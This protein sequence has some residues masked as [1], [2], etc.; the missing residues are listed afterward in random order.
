M[1]RWFLTA[2][3]CTLLAPAAFAAEGGWYVGV[4]GGGSVVNISANE[5]TEGTFN[6]E[7][8]P[9]YFVGGTVGFDFGETYPAIGT[10]RVELEVGYRGNDIDKFEFRIDETTTGTFAAD[11]DVTVFSAMVNTFGEMRELAPFYPYLGGGIGV[12]Q[13]S[14]NDVTVSGQPFADESATVFAWQL[15]GGVG[16]RLNPHLVLDLG[17]R[18]FSAQDPSFTDAAGVKFDAEYD[19]HTVLLGA[20]LDF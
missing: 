13:L 17:Y 14:L 15:G 10:G 16:I 3:L 2:A 1:K 9:G 19:S 11:G 7:Y 4:Q 5:S 18:F 20:R 8:K 12:A 6:T